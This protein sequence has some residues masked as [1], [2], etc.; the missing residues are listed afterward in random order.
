MQ[1]PNAFWTFFQ[2][3]SKKNSLTDRR[4]KKSGIESSE[5]YP[6][7]K[8]IYDCTHMLNSPFLHFLHFLTDRP[9]DRPTN[10]PTKVDI[11][12]PLTE[13]KNYAD[14]VLESSIRTIFWF[15]IN[16]LRSIQ[17]KV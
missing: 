16:L 12:A 3:F 6:T 9:T 14:V 13:L 8:I 7:I 5:V 1:S 4:T 10:G 2:E 11:E 15:K 17:F